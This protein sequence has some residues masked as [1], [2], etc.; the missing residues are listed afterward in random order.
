VGHTDGF[1]GYTHNV[2]R[3]VTPALLER[4]VPVA[5]G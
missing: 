5:S 2:T 4:G 1:G 3:N